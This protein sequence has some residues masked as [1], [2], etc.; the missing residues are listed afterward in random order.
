MRILRGDRTSDYAADPAV[1]GC[2]GVL[3]A[4]AI[5]YQ[6]TSV[7]ETSAFFFAMLLAPRLLR[8]DAFIFLGTVVAITPAW[9]GAAIITAGVGK[10]AFALAGFYVDYTQ[11]GAPIERGRRGRAL[12]PGARGSGS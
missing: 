3:M 8:R 10:V 12:R 1:A 7:A 5:A 4:A 9:L 6:Q 11:D 2:G